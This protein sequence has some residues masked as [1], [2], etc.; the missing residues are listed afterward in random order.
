VTPRGD[1]LQNRWTAARFGVD[2]QL[3]HPDGSQLVGVSEL[4]GFEPPPPEATLLRSA[5]QLVDETLRF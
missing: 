3:I 5:S 2:A 4:L 1:Y